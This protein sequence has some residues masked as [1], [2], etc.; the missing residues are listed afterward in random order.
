LEA[1]AAA[2]ARDGQ[3]ISPTGI[4]PEAMMY[5]EKQ[6]EVVALIKGMTATGDWKR[7]LLQGWGRLVGVKI[8]QH[9]YRAVFLSGWDVA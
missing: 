4:I 1:A 2:A 6:A 9:Q 8:R 5:P 3:M 7:E